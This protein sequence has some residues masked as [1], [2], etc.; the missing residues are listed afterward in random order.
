V[1][2]GRAFTGQPVDAAAIGSQDVEIEG[3]PLVGL[4]G[5]FWHTPYPI[6]QHGQS[7]IR[8]VSR[9]DGILDSSPFSIGRRFLSFRLGGTAGGGVAVELRIAQAAAAAVGA[10]ALDPPDADGDVAVR[11]ATP[12]GSDPLTQAVW[13][14]QPRRGPSLVGVVAKVRL[15]VRRTRGRRPNRLLVDH[16]RLEPRR[17][18]SFHRPLWGWADIHCHPMA[19]AGFGDT[20]HG[21]LHGPVEDLGSCLPQHGADHGNPLKLIAMAVGRHALNDGSLATTG[22]TTGTPGPEDQLAFRGWPA[23]ND[24]THIKTHQSW[25]RRAYDGGQRLMVALVVHN[26]LLAMLTGGAQRDRDTVEPQV[27]MLREFVVH[28][29]D[30]CG[31][32]RTPAEARA[33]VEQNRMA[34]VLGLETDS[35]NGW[36]KFSDFP[37]ADTP[38]NRTAIHDAIHGY[39]DYL[40]KLGIVQVNLIH[41]TDNAFGGMAVYDFRFLVSSLARSGRL[42]DTLPWSG[43]NQRELVARPAS[44]GSELWDLLKGPMSALGVM[45]PTPPA[46]GTVGIGDVNARG[47]TVA[48]EV[49]LV[50]AMRLGMVI[51][52]D[53][54]SER[55]EATAFSI[56]TKTVPQ[57]PYPL[58]A[59]HNGTRFLAPRPLGDS[60]PPTSGSRRSK[61]AWP[62]ENMKSDTQLEHIK[63]TGGIFGHGIAG[64]D[65]RS[66]GPVPNDCPGSSKTVAQGIAYAYSRLEKPVA[67]GTDWNALLEGPGP[68]FGPHAAPGLEGEVGQGDATWEAAIRAER[69]T[70]AVAQDQGVVY[71]SPIREWRSFRFHHEELFK[72]TEVEGEGPFLWQAMALLDSAVDLTSPAVAVA[73]ARP[74]TPEIPALELAQGMAGIPGRP[75]SQFHRAGV[76]AADPALDPQAELPHTRDLANVLRAIRGIRG[77]WG[78]TRAGGA[79]PLRRDTVGPMRDFDYNID[80]LAHYGLLPDMLQD[81]RNVGIGEAALANLFRSAEHYI[82]VW[83]RSV[84]TGRRIPH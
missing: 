15:R 82:E 16:V 12:A 50:E 48:G 30:W 42:P 46:I 13:D 81:L 33:L 34:F 74:G 4:G 26:E 27:Q 21:H 57:Q 35:I 24:L 71:D 37:E 80:G 53:H 65:S 5:D 18:A 11:I 52:T 3:R 7:L 73:L 49:A 60:A 41:L 17:P 9:A 36:V 40:A 75:G 64:A 1:V 84:A 61:A 62:S 2:S 63:A 43:T 58:V 68:R 23:F 32:A 54:M 45:V 55:G 39:F 72:G 77:L 20:L 10:T 67:L 38:A 47:L 78:P 31:L 6:G 44:V 29:R 59:A 56:A 66:F 51:D 76:V 25:L 14:L 69:W 79:P 28:N 8:V 19:Q 22:W 70:A 83:E